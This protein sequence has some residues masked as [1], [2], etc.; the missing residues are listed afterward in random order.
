MNFKFDSR[1]VL[2]SLK[3]KF[4]TIE[5]GKQNGEQ[6]AAGTIMHLHPLTSKSSII[7]SLASM[8]RQEYSQ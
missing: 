3:C 8:M 2:F 4:V 5:L 1:D 6:C 7:T